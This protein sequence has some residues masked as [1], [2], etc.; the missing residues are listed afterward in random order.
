LDDELFSYSVSEGDMVEALTGLVYF[1]YGEFTLLPRDENDM[2]GQEAGNGGGNNT[3]TPIVATIPD[4]RN[5]GASLGSI[6]TVNGA[7]VTHV[8]ENR[9]IAFIQDPL[10]TQDAALKLY[11]GSDP[12]GVNVD[13]VISVTGELAEYGNAL[14]I[15]EITDITVTGSDIVVPLVMSSVPSDWEQYEGMLMELQGVEVTS[16]PTQGTFETS[17]S[18]KLSDFLNSDLADD[19]VVGGTY[20]FTGFVNQYNSDYEFL[21]RDNT[22]IVVQ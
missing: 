3:G 9:N 1:S 13:E 19:V 18:I 5:G 4:L 6:V 11:F 22:D 12:I 21:T 10:E 15:K 8:S 14:Q 7:V 16:G 17:Y 2:T 20:N